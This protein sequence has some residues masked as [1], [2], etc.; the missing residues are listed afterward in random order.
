MLPGEAPEQA[1]RPCLLR[2]ERLTSP[3]ELVGRK[4]GHG[5]TERSIGRIERRL[6]V[7]G[8]AR[9]AEVGSGLRGAESWIVGR[10]GR[11]AYPGIRRRVFDLTGDYIVT[12]YGWMDDV[13]KALAD[14]T[15]RSCSTSSSA[16]TDSR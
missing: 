11:Q 16:R 2:D 15:R 9:E 12:Y 13:F 7:E 5:G 10:D 1:E 4:V 3:A 6:P 8:Q 14:P